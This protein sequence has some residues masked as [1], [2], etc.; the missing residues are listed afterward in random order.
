VALTPF[1][2]GEL[3][4]NRPKTVPV[5]V[6]NPKWGTALIAGIGFDHARCVGRLGYGRELRIRNP[7]R[8]FGD[9]RFLAQ[10]CNGKHGLGRCDGI[11]MGRPFGSESVQKLS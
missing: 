9:R 4:D 1:S 6:I 10:T 3:L 2:K 11:R 5:F 7:F 8:R